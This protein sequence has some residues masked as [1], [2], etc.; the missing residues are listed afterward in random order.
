M[1]TMTRKEQNEQ[2]YSPRISKTE[3]A[4]LS[5]HPPKNGG[6]GGGVMAASIWVKAELQTFLIQSMS[7]THITIIS[8]YL[9][10]Q[11]MMTPSILVHTHNGIP[12][13]S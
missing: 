7:G 2:L 10:I 8:G 13:I 5:P 12:I 3:K 4:T 9:T 1:D 11:H 6:R